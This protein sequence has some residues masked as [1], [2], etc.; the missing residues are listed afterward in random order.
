ML[1]ESIQADIQPSETK[2]IPTLEHNHSD[3]TRE[4]TEFLQH[5][6]TSTTQSDSTSNDADEP[7]ECI[8]LY[9]SDSEEEDDTTLSAGETTL[10]NHTQRPTQA[11]Q[12]TL[13]SSE[14]D[15]TTPEQSRLNAPHQTSA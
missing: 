2:T 8:A 3:I 15:R 14:I 10:H 7:P 4:R 6:P 11:G 1:E 9:G 5:D 12:N 13:S